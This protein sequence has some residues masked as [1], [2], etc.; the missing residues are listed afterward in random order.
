MAFLRRVV[1]KQHFCNRNQSLYEDIFDADEHILLRFKYQVVLWFELRR[2]RIAVFGIECRPLF[3]L[4]DVGQCKPDP[5][6][7][8]RAESGTGSDRRSR[9][10]GAPGKTN[11]A[12]SSMTS[13]AWFSLSQHRLPASLH[14]ACFRLSH[15][16]RQLPRC[17][18]PDGLRYSFISHLRLVT[19]TTS[20]PRAPQGPIIGHHYRC[21]STPTISH[22]ARKL[23]FPQRSYGPGARAGCS[24]EWH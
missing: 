17:L 16:R 12:R 6:T 18:I 10:N 8:A 14:L 9:A 3:T 1:G 11:G 2:P 19:S 23:P 21:I 20:D 22:P 24:E 13:E 7:G 15:L 4:G 5:G